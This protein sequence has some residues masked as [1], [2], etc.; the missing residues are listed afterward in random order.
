MVRVLCLCLLLAACSGPLNLLTGG[1]P[2]V[3]A[4][5]QAGKTNTQTIGQTNVNELSLVRPQAR[6]IK[7]STGET[8]VE[9][10]RVETVIIEQRIP[11]VYWVA[12][13]LA[14]FLD[15]PSRWPGQVWNAVR[16]RP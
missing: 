10:E 15:S 16:S 1:G 4:N 5:V 8:G 9:A 7:Q 11:L 13:I 12:L 3:A 2:K 6:T 14:I